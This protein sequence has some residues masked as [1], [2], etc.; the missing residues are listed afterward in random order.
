[1]TSWTKPFLVVSAVFI[2]SPALAQGYDIVILNGQVMDPET[3]YDAT[4]NVG[5]KDGRIAVI[6]QEEISGAETIDASGHVVTAGF[7]DQHFHWTRPVGY[8]LALRDGVTTAMDLEAGADGRRIDDWYAM[9]EGRAQVNYGT[10]SS[11]EFA[12]AAV[13]DGYSGGMDAPGAVIEGRSGENWADGVLDIDTGNRLL[14]I[15]DE[16]L[17]QGGIGVAS[18]VGYFP[19]ATARE[20]Y[21]VQRVGAHYG[22]ASFVHTRYTPGTAT[23]TVNGIQEVLINAVALDA[24]LSVSH[25]NNDGWRLVQ[26]LIVK[27]RDKGHNI[28]GEYYPYAAGSTTINAAFIRPEVW[29]EELG[30][31]Y[32]DT[33]QDPDTGEFY[34][35]TRYERDVA[36]NPTK[37]IVLYKMPPEDIPGWVALPGVVMASDAMMIPGDWDQLPWETPYEELPNLHPRTAGSHGA[38]LR[39][40]RENEI[41]LMHVLATFSYNAA[42]HLGDTGL[43][44]MQERGR[45]Q[46]GMVADIVVLE[47]ETVTDNATYAKGTLPTTGIPFVIVNGVTV[48]RD[49]KVLPDVFPGE[50]IRFSVE[51]EGRFEPLS[52]DAW[53][54]DYITAPTG[55]HGL[56]E[57]A[58]LH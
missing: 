17:R 31:R 30:H 25:F 39:I 52:E 40:A 6:T 36:E 48:V 47:P 3:R 5:V 21:E 43:K 45:M 34:D 24:P 14:E 9:H 37:Q 15:I 50:P 16:G 11:H 54:K 19:G 28:W 12:R 58:H 33:L 1:M 42:K 53:V 20:M 57:G 49:S 7:I 56:D 18:T 26:E 46:E 51:A 55:F 23:T 4:A 35:R 32:E 41:P 8:K 10:A 44:A 27:L 2:A 29:L 38:S 22:R 13:L